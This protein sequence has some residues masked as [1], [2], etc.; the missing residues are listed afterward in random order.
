M[1]Q[2][3]YQGD[4]LLGISLNLIGVFM[5]DIISLFGETNVKIRPAKDIIR[6]TIGFEKIDEQWFVSFSTIENRKGFGKQRVPVQE[7]AAFVQ[8]LENAVTNGI[9]REDEELSCVDVVK[10][11]LI[12]AEDGTVRFKT[13]PTK[14]KKPTLFQDTDDFAGAVSMLA[15]LQSMIEKKAGGLK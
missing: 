7:F 3:K 5:S 10:Q 2:Y 9:H 15:N 4:D 8:V 11:S 12:E 1:L 6:S 13:E 14:G